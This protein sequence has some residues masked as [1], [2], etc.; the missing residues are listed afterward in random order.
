MI[1]E[2]KISGTGFFNYTSDLTDGVSGSD[3]SSFG[4]DRVY[5]TYKNSVSDN[6]SFKFQTDVGR[7]DFVDEDDDGNAIVGGKSH[8]FAY[9][10]KAQLDWK[11]PISKI[12]LGMQGMNVFN[13]TEKTWGFRFI[14]K[15]PMDKHK[16][17]SSADMGIGV[18]GKFSNVSYSLLSTNG[19]GYKKEE[20]DAFKKTSIQLVYGEK[21][22]VK[23]DGF[24]I[25]T[26]LT[27]EPY[28][29]GEDYMKSVMAF[30]GGYAGSGFR[31][32]AEFDTKTD[33]KTELSEQIIAFYGSYKFTDVFEGLVYIDMYDEDTA[34][35]ED[36]E[37]YIIAGLNYYPTK[38][39]TITPN[40][41]LKSFEDG[42]DGET[43]FKM[44]FQFK[45]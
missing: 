18:S 30:F 38:G 9:I 10:K 1:G 43:V 2:G 12:T 11:T 15:S 21:K 16:F 24:N 37:T 8:L 32:G 3:K 35:D 20:S 7:F 25:G 17:S 19:A 40:V 42:S 33:S 26:S 31:V 39:L 22:L 41:R 14:E 36:G 6:I 34:T 27:F 5:F 13:V 28:H 45:F 44:N 29:D 4:F 23:K